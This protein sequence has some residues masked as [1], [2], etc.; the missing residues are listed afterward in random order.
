[1]T[2]HLAIV[3]LARFELLLKCFNDVLHTR[4]TNMEVDATMT[5][6]HDEVH[7][8]QLQFDVDRVSS[9]SGSTWNDLGCTLVLDSSL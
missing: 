3:G 9:G 4:T 7:G 5:L 8:E 2:A 6:T 1:M